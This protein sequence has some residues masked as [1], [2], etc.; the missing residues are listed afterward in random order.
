[1]AFSRPLSFR[2]MRVRCAQGHA[3]ETYRWYRSASAKNPLEPSAVT[4]FR[5]LDGVRTNSPF[6]LI[7]VDQSGG[8]TLIVYSLQCKALHTWLVQDIVFNSMSNPWLYFVFENSLNHDGALCL[9][10]EVCDWLNFSRGLRFSF[11]V[12]SPSQPLLLLGPES[13]N[14]PFRLP[15]FKFSTI[16]QLGLS[17]S[18]KERSANFVCFMV[19]KPWTCPSTSSPGRLF[20]APPLSQGKAPGPGDEVAC[21]F[22]VKK[23][24][25]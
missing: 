24:G 4:W 25:L 5:N 10:F 13:R 1:M 8:L 12:E 21:P 17:A 18:K 16:L 23:E 9:A 3:S 7:S 15:F 14:A 19:T 2:V 6:L 11:I 20:P 22:Y